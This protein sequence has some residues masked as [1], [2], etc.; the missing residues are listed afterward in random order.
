MLFGRR[1]Q[2]SESRI[3]IFNQELGT[4]NSLNSFRDTHEMNRLNM[5]APVV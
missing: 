2:N 4:V 1:N 5:L 3:Y